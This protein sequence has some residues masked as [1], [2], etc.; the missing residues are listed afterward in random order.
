MYGTIFKLNIKDG[1]HEALLNEIRQD[2]SFPAG[3]KA[4]FIMNPDEKEEWI[5]VAIFDS[6]EA[7]IANAESPEQHKRFVK[8]MLHLESEPSWTDGEFV[9]GQLNS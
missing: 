9:F 8:I 1:H 6:K 4:W 7:Y 5:G 3:M 2:K